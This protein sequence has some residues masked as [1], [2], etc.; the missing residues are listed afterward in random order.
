LAWASA[1]WRWGFLFSGYNQEHSF[2]SSQLVR[3]PF[4]QEDQKDMVSHCGEEEYH[5]SC[6]EA[7][8]IRCGLGEKVVVTGWSLALSLSWCAPPANWP[9]IVS[10]YVVETVM[11]ACQHYY[12][13]YGECDMCGTPVCYPLILMK[14]FLSLS[15]SA[16][17][18]ELRALHLLAWHSTT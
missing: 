14:I 8:S 6:L 13:E 1:W 3:V 2:W 18:F 7:L 4:G 16:L 12:R 17:G 15:F 9:F 10:I 5:H 11:S